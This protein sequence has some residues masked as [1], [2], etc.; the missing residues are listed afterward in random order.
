MRKSYWRLDQL[1]RFKALSRKEMKRDQ[2]VDRSYN[3]QLN[4]SSGG[5]NLALKPSFSMID[6][7]FGRYTEG[8]N[9][10]F[11]IRELDDTGT[12]RFQKAKSRCQF[13]VPSILVAYKFE[14]EGNYS[15]SF[16]APKPPFCWSPWPCSF[17]QRKCF[18]SF[19]PDRSYEIIHKVG[20]DWWIKRDY[21]SIDFP[22]RGN[23]NECRRIRLLERN[24]RYISLLA[25]L[26]WAF[27]TRSA[28]S[29]VRR[30]PSFTSFP[31]SRKTS[32]RRKFH[33]YDSA[34]SSGF[35]TGRWTY[36]I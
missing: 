2:V 13:S 14:Q 18:P 32:C 19:T 36:C 35:I 20:I 4:S 33:V 27:R 29:L 25:C 3:R 22:P 1:I 6:L 15:N 30:A 31:L 21:P 7:I 11:S 10:I 23:G 26:V 8:K 16:L 24:A 28:I 9:S 17:P 12:D 5:D 34:Y